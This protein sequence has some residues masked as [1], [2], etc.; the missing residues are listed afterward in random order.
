VIQGMKRFFILGVKNVR[1][2]SFLA[3]ILE[4]GDPEHV[5]ESTTASHSATPSP[6]PSLICI[7]GYGILLKCR[8][9]LKLIKYK[10]EKI[11]IK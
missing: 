11:K 6:D 5:D 3:L 4:P 10:K 1:S 9:A 7:T 8:S 2:A